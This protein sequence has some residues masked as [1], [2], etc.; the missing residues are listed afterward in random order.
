MLKGRLTD[1]DW[2]LDTLFK[3]LLLANL[4]AYHL[5]LVQIYRRAHAADLFG[6]RIVW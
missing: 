5:V 3:L 2:I 6:C 1:I 4:L